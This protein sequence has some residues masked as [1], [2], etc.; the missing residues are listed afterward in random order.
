MPTY[1]VA[2]STIETDLDLPELPST[3]RTA[4]WTVRRGHLEATGGFEPLSEVRTPEGEVWQTVMGGGGEY[5]VDFPDHAMFHVDQRRRTVTYAPV[6]EVADSTLRHLLVDQVVPRL[7]VLGGALVLHA[8]GVGVDGAGI[9][10]V[11]PTGSGKSSLAAAFV[12]RGATLL[13]DD[14]LVV[15][16]RDDRHL[17][18]PAYPGL[19][20]WSDAAQELTGTADLP[21]VAAYTSK[22][23]WAVPYEAYGDEPLPLRAF[24]APGSVPGP[25]QADLRVGRLGGADAFIV[26][27]QQAF[28]MEPPGRAREAAELD[29]FS[30]LTAQVPVLMVEHRRDFGRLPA[31]I[32]AIL[33][34][35]TR[36]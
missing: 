15:T 14:Y 27:Y 10:F 18:S 26:V 12:Q 24:V 6:D 5:V 7:L 28:R 25:G 19:R 33:E 20:L 32:D 4:E 1:A 34:E 21:E 29:R 3:D 8:S 31:V 22:R 13:A 30:R 16:E 23:R 2:G 11:G 9:A 35:I 17:A 36:T